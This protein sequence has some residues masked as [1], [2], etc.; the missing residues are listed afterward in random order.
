MGCFLA[1]MFSAAIAADWFLATRTGVCVTGCEDA[2][3]AAVADEG[4]AATEFAAV[5]GGFAAVADLGVAAAS[6]WAEAVS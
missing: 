4:E 2:G 6:V 3:F 1:G 5:A